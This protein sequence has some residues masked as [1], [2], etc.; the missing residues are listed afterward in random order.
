M[1]LLRRRGWQSTANLSKKIA[2]EK[3]KISRTLSDLQDALGREEKTVVELAAIAAFLQSIYNGIEN[4]L[5]LSLKAK[6]VVIRPSE[7]WHR[8]LIETCVSQG[9][10]SRALSDELDEYLAFRH[11]ATYSY[12]FM[13]D[14][15]R[16][17]T[18]ANNISGVY[19]RFIS[20]IDAVLEVL[21]PD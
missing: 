21:P 19:F 15:A 10:L 9:I 3:Q 16:L 7:K 8:D 4:I 18:L 2:V 12:G 6:G 1:R 5:K 17:A 11:F 14:E 13:L 20:E